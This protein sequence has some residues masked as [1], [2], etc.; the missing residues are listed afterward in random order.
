MSTPMITKAAEQR[1]LYRRLRASGCRLDYDN[2]PPSPSPLRV[3]SPWRWPTHAFPMGPGIALVLPVCIVALQA[4]TICH[5][6]LSGPQGAQFLKG[7]PDHQ[8]KAC[9]QGE[10]GTHYH[11]DIEQPILN[12]Y[13]HRPI[14]GGVLRRG[15]RIEGCFA[16]IYPPPLT[17][18]AKTNLEFTLDITDEFGDTYPFD[19]NLT[20][21]PAAADDTSTRLVTT[22]RTW[23]ETAPIPNKKPPDSVMTMTRLADAAL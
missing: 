11:L 2:L 18:R 4:R 17:F 15:S 21:D 5:F 14:H 20:C 9:C 3:S 7:C 6:G 8:C 23:E 1:N 16:L 19:F 22:Y 13:T 12:G 10:D